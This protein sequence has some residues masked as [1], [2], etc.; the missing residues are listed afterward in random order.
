M[1]YT[2]REHAQKILGIIQSL[3]PDGPAQFKATQM[4]WQAEKDGASDL[5]LLKTVTN[6]LAD[7]LNHDNWPW[8]VTVDH[9]S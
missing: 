9:D 7:G 2:V 5:D 6:T 4:Y 3:A 8:K 1:A